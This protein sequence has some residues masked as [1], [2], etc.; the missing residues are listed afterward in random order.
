MIIWLNAKSPETLKKLVR[1]CGFA[2]LTQSSSGAVLVGT[3]PIEKLELL[4][5]VDAVRYVAP[6]NR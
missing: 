4:A 2:L 3:L 1:E 6:A 5:K